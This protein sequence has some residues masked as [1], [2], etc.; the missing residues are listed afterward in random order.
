M[1]AHYHRPN[2]LL[3][4]QLSSV[5]HFARKVEAE[6]RSTEAT[7]EWNTPLTK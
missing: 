7:V 4:L 3:V 2:L 6:H 1:F 5:N